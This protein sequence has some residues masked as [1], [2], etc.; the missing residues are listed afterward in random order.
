MLPVRDSRDA[1]QR[2]ALAEADKVER[3]CI[4]RGRVVATRADEQL[5]IPVPVEVRKRGDAARVAH[6][7]APREGDAERRAA[8]EH[9]A[10]HAAIGV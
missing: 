2:A 7:V 4:E 5:R 9:M 1:A 6:R 10:L 8:H 3:T